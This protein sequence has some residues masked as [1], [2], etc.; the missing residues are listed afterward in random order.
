MFTAL[1]LASWIGLVL[2]IHAGGHNWRSS[3]LIAPILGGVTLVLITEASESARTG[4]IPMVTGD[5]G[6]GGGHSCRY[7]WAAAATNVAP[8][9][10]PE[11]HEFRAIVTVDVVGSDANSRDHRFDRFDCTAEHE[12]L[13]V[14]SHEPRCSLAAKS[15]HCA[16][17]D[18]HSQADR[19]SSRGRAGDPAPASS[20]WRRS[21]RE[22]C[23]MV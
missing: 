9:S 10:N 18:A 7:L 6:V 5:V 14:V 21:I 13:N 19:P 1:P 3:I 20:Q 15:Q 4:R 8:C 23:P 17:S 12:R 2:V 22:P 16:L 11:L